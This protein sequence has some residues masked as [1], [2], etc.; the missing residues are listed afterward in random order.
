VGCSAANCIWRHCVGANRGLSHYD[1]VAVGRGVI[2][3]LSTQLPR[4]DGTDQPFIANLDQVEGPLPLIDLRSAAADPRHVA[5]RPVAHRLRTRIADVDS[6]SVERHL[7]LLEPLERLLQRSL[8]HRRPHLVRRAGIERCVRIPISAQ[9]G[10]D[11]VGIELLRSRC[12][13]DRFRAS[14]G[15]RRGRGCGRSRSCS[16][17]RRLRTSNRSRCRSRWR[18]RWRR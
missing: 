10:L 18:R 9:R 6:A 5:L 14:N 4:V 16:R 2:L 8:V 7:L 11:G 17:G 12:W 15:V 3:L 13:N 1:H